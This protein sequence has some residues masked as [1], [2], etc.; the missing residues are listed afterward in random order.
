VIAIIGILATISVLALN[1]ARAKSRDAKRIADVKQMQTAL[2]LYFNDMG[3]YPLTAEFTANGLSSTS[4]LGTTTYMT[5]VPTAPTPSDGTCSNTDNSFYYN[6]DDGSIYSI[7][8][9][10]GGNVGSLTGG[11][12]TASPPG[13][14]YGGPG[15]ETAVVVNSCSCVNGS[16][17][18]CENCNPANAVCQG[19]TYC[20]RTA[21]CPIG[22]GCNG[23]T[24]TA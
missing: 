9:C 14:T 8:F 18:C 3:R 12:N 10:L 7:S 6:S 2:E 23:G 13:V 15:S 21:N 20:A 17:P 19:G 5:N 1:N 24:C 16:L 22:Q 11:V 4:T